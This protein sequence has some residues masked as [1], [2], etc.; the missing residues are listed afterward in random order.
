M[1]AE[2]NMELNMGLKALARKVLDKNKPLNIAL[3]SEKNPVQSGG[4]QFEQPG[5]QDWRDFYNERAAILEYDHELPR[6]EAE[7]RA[8][9]WC[10]VEWL[11]R[12]PASSD[13]GACAWCH[14]PEDSDQV[15]VPFGSSTSTW[16]HHDC[17]HPWQA[18]R[19]ADAEQVLSK[20]I[21]RNA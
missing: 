8:R 19:R 1:K 20:L 18:Q 13:P 17:W 14:K 5:P 2:L 9:E 6:A 12:N 10:V 3:N 21:S 7:S 15:V 4:V 16:L 11:N